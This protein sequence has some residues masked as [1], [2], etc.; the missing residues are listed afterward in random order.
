[1]SAASVCQLWCRFIDVYTS[2]MDRNIPEVNKAM[3]ASTVSVDLG[4]TPMSKVCEMLG[5][6]SLTL[7]T[8]QKIVSEVHKNAMTTLESSLEQARHIVRG[9][10]E[11]DEGGWYNIPS[12]L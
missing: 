6:A 4:H 9:L 5:M 8:H 2:R 10:H 3:V 11:P 1:M 7:K 12:L